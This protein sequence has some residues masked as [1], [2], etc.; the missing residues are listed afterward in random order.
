MGW[1]ALRTHAEGPLGRLSVFFAVLP[2]VIGLFNALL[3]AATRIEKG[4]ERAETRLWDSAELVSASG[5]V[6]V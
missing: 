4:L 6:S 3:D 5:V 2:F 1:T